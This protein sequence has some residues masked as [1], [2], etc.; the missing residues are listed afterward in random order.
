MSGRHAKSRASTPLAPTGALC[1]AG[2]LTRRAQ[3]ACGPVLASSARWVR[4]PTAQRFGLRR[5]TGRLPAFTLLEML[6]A[7]AMVA[8]LAGSLYASLSIAFKARR[9]AMAAVEPVRKVELALAMLGEDIRCAVVP[10]GVLA[11]PFLA[12]DAK[13]DRGR[14]SDSLEFYCTATSPEPD[15]GIGDI[16]MVELL[17]EPSDDRRSQV[18]VRYVTTN[19]LAPQ[20]VEPVREVLCRGVFAFSLR[21]FDG[22]DWLDSWDSTVE[23]NEVPGAIEVTLQLEDARQPDSALGGYFATKVFL[24]PCGPPPSASTQIIGGGSS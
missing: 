4:R 24:V 20:T 5:S 10:K 17:C 18:L 7:T 1:A 16:K 12:T 23:N 8:V 15:V 6:V 19:L 2:L 11:G 21:Y 3:H 13:D 9:S 14:D 22:S